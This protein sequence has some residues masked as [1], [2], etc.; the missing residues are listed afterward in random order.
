[1]SKHLKHSK[2]IKATAGEFG[3]FEMAILGTRCS[4]IKNLAFELSR[5]LKGRKIAFADA[6]HRQTTGNPDDEPEN[7]FIKYTDQTEHTVIQHFSK[8]NRYQRNILFNDA[9]LVLVNGNHFNASRQ[10]VVLDP[11]KSPEQKT[12]AITNPV[13]FLYLDQPFNLPDF[14]YEQ[15]EHAEQIPAYHIDDHAGIAAAIL[16]MMRRETPEVYGLVLAGGKSLRMGRDKGLIEYFGKPHRDHLFELLSGIID[17]VYYS[18]RPDQKDGL[19]GRPLIEDTITGLGPFG[20]LISAF[21]TYPNHAW[22]VLATDLPLVNEQ[23]IDQLIKGRNPSKI[24]TAFYNPET[25]FPE[26]LIAIWEPKAFP[27]L[28]D[29][30]GLGYSCPRKVLINSDIELLQTKEPEKLKNVNDPESYKTILKRLNK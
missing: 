17:H 1:M 10:I 25:D 8:L 13:I 9:D 29:F 24:A 28:L 14:I 11:D 21:R 6:V 12:G 30:L 26:P 20:A 23:M 27:V 5:H 3:R 4:R 18:V 22:L 15:I 19:K 7:M 16:T 2:T